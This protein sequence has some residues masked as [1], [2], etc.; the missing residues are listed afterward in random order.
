MFL[1][2][3][4]T[5]S[6]LKTATQKITPTL[7]SIGGSIGGTMKNSISNL[8]SLKNSSM[9]KSF[10]NGFTFLPVIYKLGEFLLN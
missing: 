6:T 2:Y 8:G 1:S 5:T 9:F 7:S 4:K 10:E 3:Q